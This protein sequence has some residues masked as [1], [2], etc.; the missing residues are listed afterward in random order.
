MY[1]DLDK[2]EKEGKLRI[3]KK[4]HGLSWGES[5]FPMAI[6]TCYQKE[7]WKWYKEQVKLGKIRPPEIIW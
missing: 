2:L 4:C 6:C 1:Y 3:C 5:P 7:Y